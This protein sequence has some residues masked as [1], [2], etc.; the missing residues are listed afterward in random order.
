MSLAFG[1]AGVLSLL[2]VLGGGR[3]KRRTAW[4]VCA[5]FVLLHAV[6]R[7]YALL[8]FTPQCG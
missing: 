7:T 3:R 1:A 6:V 4:P 2:V 8:H 5:A